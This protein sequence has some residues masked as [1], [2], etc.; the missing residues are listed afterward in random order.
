M[1]SVN[2]KSIKNVSNITKLFMLI[3]L[4]SL[5]L[6]LTGCINIRNSRDNSELRH[7]I[8]VPHDALTS[9]TGEDEQRLLETFNIVVPEDET[10]VY[11][12]SFSCRINDYV[13]TY[14]EIYFSIELGGVKDYDAF[15]AANTGRIDENGLKGKAMNQIC[16][17]GSDYYIAYTERFVDDPQF[18]SEGD[19]QVVYD[20][21]NNLYESMNR[22]N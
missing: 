8:T 19:N 9:F 2:L 11:V 4:M 17:Y 14:H 7:C 12:N 3:W 22:Q 13:G 10:E 18:L 16:N 21:F 15:Y 6:L 20:S 1:K 5:V